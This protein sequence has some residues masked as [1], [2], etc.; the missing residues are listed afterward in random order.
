MIYQSEAA[1]CGLASMA[2]IANYHGHKIDLTTLRNSYSVSFKGAN[3]QQLMSLANQLELA[4][5]ALKLELEDLKNLKTPCILHWEINHFVVLKKVHRNSITILDR[6][7]G[8]RKF[9][10]REVDK[11]FTGVALELSPT[12]GFKKVDEKVKIGLTS[13]WT[14]VEGLLPSLLKLFALSLI[15]QVFLLASPYYTQLVVDEVL[16]SNDK[17]LLTILALG[18]GL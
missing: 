16:I 11:A 15:L 6:A 13:F 12:N 18:F 3:L 14:K 5:R 2:M 8:E 4:S 7:L 1:E 10:L 9:T 17:P